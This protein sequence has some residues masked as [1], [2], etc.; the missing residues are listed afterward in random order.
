MISEHTCRLVPVHVADKFDHR[1]S[2]NLIL[3][4]SKMEKK[5]RGTFDFFEVLF[6]KPDSLLGS[7]LISEH[8]RRLVSVHVSDKFHHRPSIRQNHIGIAT[9]ER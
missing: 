5:G 2:L 8:T 4:Q 6:Q 7:V 9:C 3:L 1:P